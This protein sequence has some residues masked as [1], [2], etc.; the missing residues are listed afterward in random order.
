ME[1]KLSISYLL[2]KQGRRTNITLCSFLVLFAHQMLLFVFS[3]DDVFVDVLLYR[4]TNKRC[5]SHCNLELE[6]EE[7]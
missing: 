2:E 5:S 1:P 7:I 6:E 4:L 3:F